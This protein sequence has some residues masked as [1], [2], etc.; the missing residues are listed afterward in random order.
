M[1][2]GKGHIHLLKDIFCHLNKKN[3]T[4]LHSKEEMLMPIKLMHAFYKSALAKKPINLKTK[5]KFNK[6]GN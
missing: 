1:A 3:I 5:P 4:S 6:L 2:Y